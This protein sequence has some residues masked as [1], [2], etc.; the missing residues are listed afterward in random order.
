MA[1]RTWVG[2]LVRSDLP[3]GLG[4]QGRERVRTRTDATHT[5]AIRLGM[6]RNLL[7]HAAAVLLTACAARSHGDRQVEGVWVGDR[8]WTAVECEA[9]DLCDRIVA[10]ATNAFLAR[11]PSAEIGEVRFHDLPHENHDGEA[12]TV[13][14]Q[15]YRIVFTLADGSEWI[16]HFGCDM[17]GGLMG[18]LGSPAYA[19]FCPPPGG[20]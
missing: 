2:P 9:E 8:S 10:V 6:R 14:H 4:A 11:M 18:G 5:H 12:L 20:G 1:C 3:T 13:S 7:L 17:H 16:E 15:T 19:E